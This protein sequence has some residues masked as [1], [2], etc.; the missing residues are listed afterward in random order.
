M[1][2]MLGWGVWYYQSSP[3]SVSIDPYDIPEHPKPLKNCQRLNWAQKTKK[4]ESLKNKWEFPGPHGAQKMAWGPKKTIKKKPF[5]Q[6]VMICCCFCNFPD[7]VFVSGLISGNIKP[8]GGLP[9]TNP[10]FWE[11][12]I[13]PKNQ[14]LKT[15]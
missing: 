8:P 13:S 15:G 10:G 11:T 6:I 9:G 1:M 7:F 4:F 2:K 3:K 12:Q 14:G 5:Y